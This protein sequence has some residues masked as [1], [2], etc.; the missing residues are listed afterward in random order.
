MKSSTKDQAKGK[1]ENVYGKIQEKIGEIK[2]AVGEVNIDACQKNLMALKKE[3]TMF[4]TIFVI[5]TGFVGDRI[6]N[7]HHVGRCH[8]CP[9]GHRHHCVADPGA[10]RTKTGI[11]VR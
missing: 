7:R 9:A 8:S 6:T 2:D 3:A 4:W 10:S 5:S 1:A 11:T